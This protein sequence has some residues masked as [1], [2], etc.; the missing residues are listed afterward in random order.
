MDGLMQSPIIE[1]ENITKYYN[2]R[3][4]MVRRRGQK[5]S[6]FLLASLSKGRRESR[7]LV[8]DDINFKIYPGEI[9]G[10]IGSNGS[11]K[12]TLLR[13]LTGISRP[14][15]GRVRIH[16]SYRELFALNA[17]FNMNLSGRKNIYLYAAMKYIPNQVIE[18]K[19]DTIIEYSGLANFIDEPV[20]SYSSGMRS[21]LGFS[22]IINTLPEII[23]IDEALSPGDEAFREKCNNT[24]LKLK[25]E[26]KTIM[27]V[28][29]S[30]P[31]LRTLCTR[32]I[33][34]DSGRIKMDGPALKVIHEYK[35]FQDHRNNLI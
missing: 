26:G 23:F 32:A 28:S 15:K 18:E 20:K 27:I 25:D 16:D 12:S 13:I 19:I 22:I 5:L 1:A 21:R 6:E 17:G 34:L 4:Q 8:L 2:R 14:T 31:T 11:G 33:W 30:L 24:L 7:F 35:V 3:P 10:L 29:H 9:V